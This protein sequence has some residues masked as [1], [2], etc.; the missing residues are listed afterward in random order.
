MTWR[1][2]SHITVADASWIMTKIGLGIS[3]LSACKV[4]LC[5][6]PATWLIQEQTSCISMNANRP[7][8]L[9]TLWCHQTVSRFTWS[10][11][12]NDSQLCVNNYTHVRVWHK[13]AVCSASACVKRLL[14]IHFYSH[15]GIKDDASFV[16]GVLL[17]VYWKSESTV[18]V[19]CKT[20]FPL[21]LSHIE[22]G[23]PESVPTCYMAQFLWVFFVFF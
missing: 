2:L 6:E 15:K 10:I 11:H 20:A 16:C 19:L 1:A 7:R 13:V 14:R 5:R 21:R 4:A 18:N 12:V 9:V 17:C 23:L 8:C 22:T 3:I